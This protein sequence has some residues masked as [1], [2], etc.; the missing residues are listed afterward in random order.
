ML[1]VSTPPVTHTPA[2]A[3]PAETPLALRVNQRLA[4]QVLGVQDDQVTLAING[5]RVVARLT[6]PDQAGALSERRVAQFVVRGLVDQTL[7]LQLVTGADGKAITRYA[8]GPELAAALLA[9]AGLPE[10]AENLMLA[11]ALVGRNLP[12]NLGTLRELAALLESVSLNATGW[13]Q[14]DAD[15][16]ATLKAAGL[17]LSP[18]ALELV[19]ASLPE[20]ADALGQLATRLQALLKENLPG[21]LAD[22][23]R[24]ALD[25]LKTLS[26]HADPSAQEVREAV[27]VLGRP[28]ENVLAKLLADPNAERGLLTL[29]QLQHELARSAA[30]L[31]KEAAADLARALDALRLMQLGNLPPERAATHWLQFQLPLENAPPARLRI[32][33]RP[34]KDGLA[35]VDAAR[36]RLVL[37]VPLEAGEMIE[38]DLSVLGKQVSAWVTA[39]S[40][41]LRL[42]AEAELPDLQSGLSALGFGCK[43]AHVLVGQPT[44]P[45]CLSDPPADAHAHTLAGVNIK[46]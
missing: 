18:G 36:T 15:A 9:E 42:A 44:P 27:T 30:P 45:A 10:T 8:S 29:A 3:R 41:D 25:L 1:P 35:R 40:D 13:T 20:A 26:L 37:Q 22:S 16:A 34:G 12:L 33:G 46:A 21:P 24:R 43:S 39:T 23:V 14:A 17:P 31:A 28:L 6:N 2:V 11:R 38:V 7:A 19:K 4:A 32:A 5:A